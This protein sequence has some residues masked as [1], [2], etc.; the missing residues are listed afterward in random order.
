MT[1]GINDVDEDQNGYRDR[2]FTWYGRWSDRT[3][4]ARADDA[5]TQ[6]LR[7]FS[8]TC[9]NIQREPNAPQVYI[10]AL[11]ANSSD[12]NTAFDNCAPGRVYRT[13]SST[14]L[15]AAFQS[16]AAELIDLH[17]VQ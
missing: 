10:I 14:Q 2:T 8:K 15:N 12:V 4:S 17:L 7:R 1:D 13:S 16:V 5:E 3:I 11:V 9:S 6:M